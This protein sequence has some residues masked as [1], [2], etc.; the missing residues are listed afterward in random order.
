MGEELEKRGAYKRGRSLLE[1][2]GDIEKRKGN[3]S[4][5]GEAH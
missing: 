4:A 1:R 5:R 3:L 2:G